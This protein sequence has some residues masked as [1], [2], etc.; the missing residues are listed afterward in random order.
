[1]IF[2]LISSCSSTRFISIHEYEA[3]KFIEMG[4][5]FYRLKEYEKSI[6]AYKSGVLKF[7]GYQKNIFILAR[8]IKNYIKL[9]N[10]LEVD[11]LKLKLLRIP[12]INNADKETHFYILGLIDLFNK[13]PTK[14]EKNFSIAKQYSPKDRV[15]FFDCLLVTKNFCKERIS[16]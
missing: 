8:L 9:G 1:M 14:A 3:Q 10:T 12:L 13:D 16:Q 4:D 7:K 15:K 11:Q 5:Q 6:M 2:I